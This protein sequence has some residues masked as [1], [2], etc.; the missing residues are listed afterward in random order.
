MKQKKTCNPSFAS[1]NVNSIRNKHAELF[2]IFD[3]NI[4]ILTTAETK[5]DCS[6]PNGTVPSWRIQG[7]CS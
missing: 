2:T 1:I 4:D 3:S 6:F 5:L 7:T